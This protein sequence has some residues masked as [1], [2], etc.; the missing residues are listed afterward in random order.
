ML[1]SHQWPELRDKA[2]QISTLLKM[3]SSLR[4]SGSQSVSQ[5]INALISGTR[6][7]WVS[8]H[9]A[10]VASARS[11]TWTFSADWRSCVDS[12]VLFKAHLYVRLRR[13]CMPSPEG[14][15]WAPLSPRSAEG[16]KKKKVI[17]V[18]H[19]TLG[20]P[21]SASCRTVARWTAALAD[22][23]APEWCF[24]SLNM[25]RKKSW[26][27]PQI[28]GR[29]SLLRQKRISDTQVMLMKLLPN[30]PKSLWNWRQKDDFDCCACDEISSSTTFFFFFC[31]RVKWWN[32]ESILF[33]CEMENRLNFCSFPGR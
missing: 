1:Q 25:W 8:I 27:A 22:L 12:Q 3:C 18:R 20:Q 19:Q 9:Y 11:P 30:L 16:K 24:K 33:K 7:H 5:T 17:E 23:S 26:R 28:L 2:K 10:W 31:S 6:H 21:H 15:K 29:R 14:L 4:C 32:Q 13:C